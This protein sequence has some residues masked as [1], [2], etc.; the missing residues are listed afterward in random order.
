[1]SEVRRGTKQVSRF[2]ERTKWRW[3]ALLLDLR[4]EVSVFFIDVVVLRCDLDAVTE[5]LSGSGEPWGVGMYSILS[6]FTVAKNAR[7]GVVLGR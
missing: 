2:G 4:A 3:S 5:C 7:E 6:R 1:M